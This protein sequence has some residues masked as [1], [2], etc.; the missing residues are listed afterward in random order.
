MLALTMAPDELVPLTEVDIDYDAPLGSLRAFG[1]F[2]RMEEEEIFDETHHLLG[3]QGETRESLRGVHRVELSL[4]LVPPKKEERRAFL[5]DIQILLHDTGY[6]FGS[7]REL[8]V[9]PRVPVY[10]ESFVKKGTSIYGLNATVRQAGTHYSL[11]VRHAMAGHDP[12]RALYFWSFVD[13]VFH[14]S[15]LLVRYL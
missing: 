7:R 5:A 3:P 1:D 11:C 10:R 4:L 6:L 2:Q 9:L 14:P 12:F 8:L 13:D 15:L